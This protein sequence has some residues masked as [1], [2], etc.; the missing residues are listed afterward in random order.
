MIRS[1]DIEDTVA[2]NLENKMNPKK[3][4]GLP[5]AAAQAAAAPAA[6]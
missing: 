6:E 4:N 1:T 5:W 2:A 3:E